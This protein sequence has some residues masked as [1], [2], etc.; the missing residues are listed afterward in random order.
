MALW[1]KAGVRYT[2]YT[3]RKYI[4]IPLRNLNAQDYLY[5]EWFV[6]NFNNHSHNDNVLL[7]HAFICFRQM[8][9]CC[10]L[11]GSAAGSS[12]VFTQDVI[13]GEGP[14]LKEGD[15]AQVSMST[16]NITNGKKGDQVCS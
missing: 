3:M 12:P 8:G 7:D 6:Y 10:A 5:M 15:Q 13:V 4:G 9:I 14:S 16:W 11:V 2:L 1:I